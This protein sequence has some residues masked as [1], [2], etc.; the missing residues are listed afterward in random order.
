MDSVRDDGIVLAGEPPAN[1]GRGLRSR[2]SRR[3]LS[4]AI[5]MAIVSIW[6]IA[7]RAGWISAIF[8]PAPSQTLKWMAG[9]DALAYLT[10]ATAITLR[11]VAIGL[12][13]GALPAALL[14][15]LIGWSDRLRR[16]VDPFLAALHPIPKIAL[17]PLLIV[18]FGLGETPQVAAIAIGAF[19]P[20][21][22][23]AAAG[24][25]QINPTF[26]E[27]A[28]N[29]GASEWR[30]FTA[31]VVP[32]SIPSIVIGMRLSF[33]VALL[34][35]ISTEIAA[36][37]EGI[38]TVLWFAWETFRIEQLYAGLFAVSAV[39]IGFNALWTA[40]ARR[41]VPWQSHVGW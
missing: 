40:A 10:G 34:I 5:L 27:V 9:A 36:A 38:G 3:W 16:V 19:F 12:L 4:G 28:R 33:N 39:G 2:L 23:T 7:A 14:G 41:L 26:F 11:R 18:V 8:F 24:A 17:F 35:S 15:L 32:A 20:M 30:T 31:V 1:T 29:Y 6:E 22:L 25:R 37:R 13:C 21:A